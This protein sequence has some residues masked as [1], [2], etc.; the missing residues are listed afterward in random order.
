MA[1]G[2]ALRYPLCLAFVGTLISIFFSLVRVNATTVALAM[3]LV[4]LGVAT[5]WGLAEAIF[6]SILCVLGFNY[7]FLP[8]IGTFTIADPQNWAALAAFLGTS[9]ESSRRSTRQTP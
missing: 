1:F 6:T 7:F 9:E 8:P 4:V 5:R 2:R 3:L